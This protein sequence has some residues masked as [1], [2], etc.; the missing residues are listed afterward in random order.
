[1]SWDTLTTESLGRRLKR[2]EI[3]TLPGAAAR[4]I[5]DVIVAQTDVRIALS[6]NSSD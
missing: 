1:M 3:R 2:R 5:F 6:L 4:R